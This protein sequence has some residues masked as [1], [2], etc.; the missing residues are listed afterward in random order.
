M[1]SFSELFRKSW[2]AVINNPGKARGRYA[3]LFGSAPTTAGGVRFFVKYELIAELFEATPES[4]MNIVAWCIEHSVSEL[5]AKNMMLSFNPQ[6]E[7]QA[8]LAMAIVEI[9]AVA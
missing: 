5:S 8:A 9:A 7:A 4:I 3:E 6:T 1:A 2:Q